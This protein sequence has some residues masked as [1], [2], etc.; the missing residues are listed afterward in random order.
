MASLSIEERLLHYFI[1]MGAQPAD[2]T[3]PDRLSFTIGTE[4][5]QVIILRNEVLTRKGAII[6][7]ILNIATLRGSTNQL[8][9][10]APRLLGA[11]IDAEVF[12]QYGIGLILFDDRRIDES[13]AP[14]PYQPPRTEPAPVNSNPALMTELVTLKSMYAA[15]EK[16]I[17]ELREDLRTL[18]ENAESSSR[19]PQITQ[20]STPITPHQPGFM[21]QAGQLPSFF[22]NNPWLDLLSKRGREEGALAG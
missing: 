8:Y 20:Q 5:V 2:Q 3:T 22:N 6:E 16:R 7:S 15:M 12:R 14:K 21:G 18:R 10:A 9:L 19:I 1:A 11:T 17:G 13:V 4:R